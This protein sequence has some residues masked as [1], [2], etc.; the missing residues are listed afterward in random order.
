MPAVSAAVLPVPGYVIVEGN[1][2]DVSGAVYGC[3]ERVDCLTGE[4]FPLRPYVSYS[5]DGCLALSCGQG[6][7]WD[8]EAP[9][10]RCVYYCGTAMNAA[11]E[12][13]TQPAPFLLYDT[14][15]R[16]SVA[17]WGTATSGQVYVNSGGAAADH[18]VTGT[19][20]QMATVSV[21]TDYIASLPMTTPNADGMVTAF[22]AALALTATTEMHLW[23]RS[24]GT[25]ANGYRLVSQMA[26]S[27]NVNIFLQ[28]VV[29][30]VITTLATQSAVMTYN[31]T[32]LMGMRL[33][34]WGNQ[35]SAMV[36]DN[37]G[38][39]PANFQVTATD[40]TFTA[41]GR[42]NLVARR[43]AGNTNGT[44]NFQWDNLFVTDVCADLVPV[45]ACSQEVVVPSGGCFRLGD[46]VRPCNDQVV[47][48]AD[49][50]DCVPNQGIFFGSMDT[51]AYDDNSAQL[52]PVNARRPIVVSRQRRDVRSLLN[53]VTA[54]FPDRDAV[55]ALN[56]PGSPLL[57]RG[58]ADYGIPDRYMAVLDLTVDRSFSDHRQQPRV[59]RMPHVA[60]D[61]PVGPAQGICGTR[62]EDLCDRFATWD[63]MTAAGLTWADLLR[64]RAGTG[65]VFSPATW[66]DV[67]AD[68][69]NWT[70]LNANES[71][72]NDAW[73]GF[74]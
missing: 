48:L 31:A 66:A 47:C 49:E 9:L 6:I 43:G 70:A 53:L 42:L 24:D 15:T 36:W 30:G 12:T 4:R 33:R 56:E 65:I 54:T 59:V 45:Q 29:A 10:D 63:A 2:A 61:A 27:G 13:I 28:R 58:P 7:W 17:S 67:N 37:T 73:L 26:T 16:V 72:W 39:M 44:I 5:T 19:R 21:A 18:S 20:G 71:D 51:E 11:G 57:W 1:F 41:P 8:T 74:P 64:G 62:V 22:P 3:I 68:F 38:P 52:L 32:T 55:L 14:F 35:L 40:S 50:G 69:A 34:A 25:T 46:P 60:V 23:L